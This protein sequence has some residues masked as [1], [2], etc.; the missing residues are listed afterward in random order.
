MIS[1]PTLR[2]DLMGMLDRIGHRMD[3]IVGIH[4]K[5]TIHHL[6]NRNRDEKNRLTPETPCN[7]FNTQTFQ[8]CD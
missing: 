3:N 6:V 8:I 1:K 7:L 2:I 4:V 5:E